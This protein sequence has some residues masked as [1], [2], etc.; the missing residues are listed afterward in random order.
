MTRSLPIATGIY[1]K[2]PLLTIY[3]EG[4]AV[5][6]IHKTIGLIVELIGVV[7]VL[8]IDLVAE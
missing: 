7:Y 3:I 1:F 6:D 4:L 5:L 2:S 8:G